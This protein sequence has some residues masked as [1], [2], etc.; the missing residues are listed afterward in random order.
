MKTSLA[1]LWGILVITSCLA[2]AESVQEQRFEGKYYSGA[3]DAEYIELL[4][5]SR[6]M[7]D[8]DPELPNIAMFYKPEWNGFVLSPDWGMWW[9]QNTY[10]TTYCALPF[11]QE[12]Y[13]TWLQNAQDLWYQWMG[14][15]KT[16]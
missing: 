12:P 6:R 10:G 3:G 7:F 15:G 2:A 1:V 13:I 16:E 8:P 9:V 5:L 14:D 11:Y 4:D